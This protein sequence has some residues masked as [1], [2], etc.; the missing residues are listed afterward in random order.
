MQERRRRLVQAG[1]HIRHFPAGNLNIP[2]FRRRHSTRHVIKE[3]TD[4][5]L[6]ITA[7]RR[8]HLAKKR[9]LRRCG[10]RE[11]LCQQGSQRSVLLCKNARDLSAQ[12][13]HLAHRLE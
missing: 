1:R 11:G 10:R 3:G 5:D 12:L 13:C 9:T 6:R 8:H 2:G 7:W 4:D